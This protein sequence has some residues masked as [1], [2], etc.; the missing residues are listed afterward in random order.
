M[1]RWGKARP[2]SLSWK[3]LLMVVFLVLLTIFMIFE[4]NI[5]PALAAVAEARAR[6]IAIEAMTEAIEKEIIQTVEYQDLIYIHKD[7]RNRPVLLQPNTI[8][9]SRLAARTTEHVKNRLQS[10]EDEVI[11]LPL[12]Q[13]F[14]SDLLANMGPRFRLTVMPIGTVTVNL[15]NELEE[16]GINQTLHKI[17]LEINAAIGIAVP[18]IATKTDVQHQVLLTQAVIV[19]EVPDTFFQLHRP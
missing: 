15:V 10:L 1:R 17:I 6:L 3:A 8:A 5:K 19:G 7:S 2:R 13:V 14:G 4:G 11:L 16:A 12:G 9:I 18:M